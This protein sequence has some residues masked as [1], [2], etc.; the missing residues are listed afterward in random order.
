MTLIATP[1][2]V[3]ANSYVTESV[4]NTYLSGSRLYI[5]KWVAADTTT[6]E[7]AL[8]WATSLLDQVMD[9]Y[10][11]IRTTEQALRWP[12]SGVQDQDY[13][14]IDYDTI[15]PLLERATSELAL[16]LLQRDRLKDPALIGQGFKRVKVGS[17]EIE[18][19]STK[20]TDMIPSNIYV[21][22]EPFGVP[23]AISVSGGKQIKVERT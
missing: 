5:A 19:D 21:M 3:N 2:A 1:K 13:R 17:I 4:A 15:P 12:R 20:L 16:Y 8:I 18:V 6:R 10:G 23:K 22:L 11:A 9:W 7:T 14:N